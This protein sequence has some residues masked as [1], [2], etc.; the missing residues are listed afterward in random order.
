MSKKG[1]FAFVDGLTG[2]FAGEKR[3][4]AGVLTSSRVDDVRTGVESAIAQVRCRRTVLIVD[5]VDV[6]LAAGEDATSTSLS[7]MLLSLR[8]VCLCP[9]YICNACVCLCGLAN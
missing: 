8:E 9:F 6:L 7:A 5:Q 1:R 4:Q 2:L 3:Q